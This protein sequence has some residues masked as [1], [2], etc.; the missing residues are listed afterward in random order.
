MEKKYTSK[1]GIIF[2][3]FLI[4]LGFGAGFYTL[5][6][7][8]QTTKELDWVDDPPKQCAVGKQKIRGNLGSAR[9][10]SIARGRTK[11]ALKQ[12]RLNSTQHFQTR[13]KKSEVRQGWLYSLVCKVDS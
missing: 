5:K 11:L 2:I 10:V 7:G 6:E 1:S 8:Q 13:V 9:G 12:G 4:L 3:C